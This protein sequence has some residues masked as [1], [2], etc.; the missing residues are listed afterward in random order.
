MMNQ[1]SNCK[2]CARQF[3]F[4]RSYRAAY[5]AM[6]DVKPIYAD[7]AD[8][9]AIGLRESALNEYFFQGD[10]L[11]SANLAAMTKG[12]TVPGH[13][14]LTEIGFRHG[15]GKLVYPKFRFEP[16]WWNDVT[17]LYS[18]QST[19]LVYKAILACS[20]GVGQCMA[21]HLVRGQT[22]EDA[23]QTLKAFQRDNVM[24]FR[25][26]LQQLDQLIGMTPGNRP[27]A[28]T[29]YNAGSSFKHVS[30][31]GDAVLAQRQGFEKQLTKLRYKIWLPKN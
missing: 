25:V 18:S 16:S 22:A 3:P 20:W 1:Q 19:P 7:V 8:A 14:F 9:L 24:Q 17:R 12:S 2:P 11:L 15:T 5:K 23:V 26:M 28:Y 21:L 27:L 30:R 6:E 10:S 29:R 13:A 31:Y 4:E